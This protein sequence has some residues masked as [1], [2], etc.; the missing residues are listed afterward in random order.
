MKLNS[1]KKL[2][3]ALPNAVDAGENEE[4]SQYDDN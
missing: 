3:L 2:A 1:E 4:E